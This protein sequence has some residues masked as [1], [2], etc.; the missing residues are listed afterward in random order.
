MIQICIRINISYIFS[1]Q[2]LLLF[3]AFIIKYIIAYGTGSICV[4]VQLSLQTFIQIIMKK[5][6]ISTVVALMVAVA[7]FS[8][9]F[10]TTENKS[11]LSFDNVEALAAREA[12]G[13]ICMMF[14]T[15]DCASSEIK[16]YAVLE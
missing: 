15:L 14:G 7:A 12:G 16:V 10:S 9:N 2:A 8:V 4:W 11:N 6:L 13:A 5:I 3:F 1:F